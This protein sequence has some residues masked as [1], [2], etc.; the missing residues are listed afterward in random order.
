VLLT[1]TGD[2]AYTL[3]AGMSP[4][5]AQKSCTVMT[6][7]SQLAARWRN[8]QDMP[9]ASVL[10]KHCILQDLV[11]TVHGGC[12]SFPCRS[13]LSSTAEPSLAPLSHLPTV[14]SMPQTQLG[15]GIS[16]SIAAKLPGPKN[17]T[18]KSALLPTFLSLPGKHVGQLLALFFS[19][20]QSYGRHCAFSLTPEVY[21]FK[22]TPPSV[23]LFPDFGLYLCICTL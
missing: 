2:T 16:T 20:I 7:L 5:L 3:I 19:S 12:C 10:R 4:T 1:N 14:H 9:S 23:L 21:S 13:R 8:P 15:R 17:K 22:R 6:A 11:R 18:N